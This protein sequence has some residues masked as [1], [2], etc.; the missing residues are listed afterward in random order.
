MATKKLGKVSFDFQLRKCGEKTLQVVLF[1]SIQPQLFVIWYS[2]IEK[3]S[4]SLTNGQISQ[5]PAS[6]IESYL[7]T[8]GH[9]M[10]SLFA[11]R[12]CV[13]WI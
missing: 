7:I 6:Q 8:G 2:H 12:V 4:T 9:F 10:S 3:Y 11:L 5:S 1:H 13:S